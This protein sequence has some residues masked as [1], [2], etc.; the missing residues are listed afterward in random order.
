MKNIK[1]G[2][3]VLRRRRQWVT[4]TIVGVLVEAGL[5]PAQPFRVPVRVDVVCALLVAVVAYPALTAVL[6][7]APA[8]QSGFPRPGVVIVLIDAAVGVVVGGVHGL[9]VP[10]REHNDVRVFQ[11]IQ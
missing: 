10:L 2:I 1:V 9:G 6:A 11:S 7:C 4:G 5:S 8:Y 3:R